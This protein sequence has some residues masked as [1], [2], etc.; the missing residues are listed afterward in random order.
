M[1]LSRRIQQLEESATLAVSSKAAAMQKQ[2]IDVVS[3]GAGE[4]DFGTPQH[5]KDACTAALAAGHTGYAKPASG[6][7]AA[8]EAVC[9][10]LKRENG[11]EYKPSQVLITVGGKEALFLAT[12]CLLDEGDEAILPV[13][14]WVSYPEQIKLA[15][16]KVVPVVGDEAHS[17][18]LTADQIAKA[19]TPRTRVLIFNSP[20]NPGGFTYSPEEV[21]AIADVVAAHDI[22][23]F[24]DEMY[25]RLI[26]GNQRFMSFAAARPDMFEKTLT[27]NAGS[28]TYSMTG[29]RVGYV[30]GP[31]AIISQMAKLQSQTTSGTATFNQH[32]LAAALN[33]D[34]APVEAMRREFERR[35]E[36]MHQRLNAI[37]GVTCVKPTGAFY[38]FPNVSG[39][40][41]ALGVKGSLEFSAKVLEEAHVALVPGAAFGM[42]TNVR[43]SF[44]TSMDN[45]RKGLD[46]LEQLLGKA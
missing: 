45:I 34:Q 5:I 24:S 27:F 22:I 36:Y 20:S 29:W 43:L 4:P 10:K 46:R 39:A 11:L 8:K 42:D 12:M 13:P 18:K 44:A 2:G 19:I 17:Y 16:A 9:S 28:K 15:G 37:K 23:V 31:Q 21:K 33:G 6:I 14:Y 26:Y 7:L 40:F 30:A 35:A 38:A 1:K 3:F 41:A 25:D 32:A